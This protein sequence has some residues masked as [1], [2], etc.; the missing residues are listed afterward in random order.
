VA[1]DRWRRVAVLLAYPALLTA[2]ACFMGT[3]TRYIYPLL[4][5]FYR[6]LRRPRHRGTGGRTGGPSPPACTVVLAFLGMVVLLPPALVIVRD[7]RR[8]PAGRLWMPVL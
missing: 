6:H 4:T 3:E 8:S 7:G 1:S 5:P 2:M